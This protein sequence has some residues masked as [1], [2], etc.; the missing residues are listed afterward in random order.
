MAHF[1]IFASFSTTNS[2]ETTIVLYND[3]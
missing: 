2:Q 1:V 3:G